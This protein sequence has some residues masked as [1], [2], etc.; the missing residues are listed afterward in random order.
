MSVIDVFTDLGKTM[1]EESRKDMGFME[2]SLGS[3]KVWTKKAG[4]ELGG[5]NC[6]QFVLV[7]DLPF[8]PFLVTLNARHW[9]IW[10]FDL[11]QYGL[12]YHHREKACTINII[13]SGRGWCISKIVKGNSKFSRLKDLHLSFSWY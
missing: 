8:Y 1:R 10:T 11:I 6:I 12:S 2:I 9:A 7:F 13:M 4:R 5:N 3:L